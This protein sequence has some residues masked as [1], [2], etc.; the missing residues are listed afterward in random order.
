MKTVVIINGHPRSGKDTFIDLTKSVG[1]YLYVSGV[2]IWKT[3]LINPIKEAA[4]KLGWTYEKDDRARKFL[5]DLKILADRTY[6]FSE[7]FA[8]GWAK[9]FMEYDAPGVL[10]M[11][12]REP[13]DID[14]IKG[15]A[16]EFGLNAVTLFI[17]RKD[18][19][20]DEY[21]CE[22]DAGVEEYSYDYTISNDGTIDDLKDKALSFL[23]ALD[24]AEDAKK[25][26]D[27]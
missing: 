15:A 25:R 11:Q 17:S 27:Q 4:L 7:D 8:K 12:A 24:R 6:G 10:F 5:S 18:A 2:E 22:A 23:Q 21:A 1:K 20:R 9:D 26:G 19:V 13:K 3:S 16:E 14:M